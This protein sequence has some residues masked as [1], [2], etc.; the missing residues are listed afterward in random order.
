MHLEWT[1]DGVSRQANWPTELLGAAPKRLVVGDDTLSADAA[2]RLATQGSAIVWR[3]DF[4]NARQLLQGLA[5]RVDKPRKPPRPGKAKVEDH[6]DTPLDRF[7]RH[8]LRQ[9]QRTDLLN[10]LLIPIQADGHIPLRRAP[11]V[12]G[13]CREALG[14][15]QEDHL[16]PLRALQGIIGA[17]EWRKKGV[18]VPTLPLPI[19]VHYGVF[20]PVR[21][22]YLE[23]VATAPLPST[24]LAFDV[25]TGSGVLAALLAQRGVRRVVATDQDPRALACAS[26]NLRAM[27]LE[28]VV[29]LQQTDMFPEGSSPLIVCNPPWIPARPTTSLEHAIYDPD[30]RMLLAFLNGLSAHL[31]P[32][33]EGWLIM[34]DLAEHLGLRS[35]DFLTDA[36]AAAGLRVVDRLQAR[37]KHPKAADESDPLHAARRLEVT[38]LWR[39][40]RGNTG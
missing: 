20:S 11:D 10:R 14:P 19:H 31:T 37:P 18:A 4:H 23:L 7:N 34:S 2:Y 12:A 26:D 40:T 9:S 8:R 1:E 25:G 13:A 6:S 30:S 35:A 29:T 3:G 21:G 38:S 16:L 17:H 28:K 24:E 32:Q 39:L 36:I 5:R 15:I 27:G 22:E 33:G